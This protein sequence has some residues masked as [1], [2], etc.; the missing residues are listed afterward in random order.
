MKETVMILVS[1]VGAIVF[2]VGVAWYGAKMEAETYTQL[3]GKPVT[4][5]Q[6]LW[7]ELRV[8]CK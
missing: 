4:T 1:I 2:S 7:V 8:D 5:W 6:A 3:T